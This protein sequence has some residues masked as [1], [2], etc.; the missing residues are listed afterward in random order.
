MAKREMAAANDNNV[1]ED[2]RF[3]A[4]V[5]DRLLLF[6]FVAITVVGTA[7][8]LLDTPY[9]WD[10]VDQQALKDNWHHMH[11]EMMKGPNYIPDS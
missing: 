3:L 2:W 7:V 10:T 8:I 1:I 6:V 9:L 5:F 4:L 11:M